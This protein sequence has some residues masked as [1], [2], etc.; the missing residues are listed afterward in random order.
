MNDKIFKTISNNCYINNK[1][2]NIHDIIIPKHCIMY[3]DYTNNIAYIC[4]HF[5]DYNGHA[6]KVTLRVICY[7]FDLKS[8]DITFLHNEIS[9]KLFEAWCAISRPRTKKIIHEN[10]FLDY[11]RMMHHARRKKSGTGGVRLM[12]NCDYT[13]DNLKYK[14]VTEDA[15]WAF[16]GNASVVANSIRY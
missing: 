11:Q 15:H 3:I 4:A 9:M 16:S 1:Q 13:I 12:R 10:N 2:F 5:P 14:E 8:I 7:D 6:N